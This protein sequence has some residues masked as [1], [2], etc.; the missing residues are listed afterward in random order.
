MLP[1]PSVRV[2]GEGSPRATSRCTTA[3][4]IVGVAASA[5]PVGRDARSWRMP[6]S[7]AATCSATTTLRCMPPVQPNAI[8]R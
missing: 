5:V 7:A 8:V 2:F 3:T 1:S 4:S 6:S